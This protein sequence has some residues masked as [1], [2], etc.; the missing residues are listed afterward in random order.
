MADELT[1]PPKRPELKVER[2]DLPDLRE[3]F[4]DSIEAVHFDGQSLRLT[5][6]VMRFDPSPPR[7]PPAT[8]RRYPACRLVLTTQAG[9]ELMNQME[10]LKSGLVQAGLLKADS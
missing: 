3:T 7:T 10:K 1:L 4:A 6:S 5:F 9:I 8:A 2:V